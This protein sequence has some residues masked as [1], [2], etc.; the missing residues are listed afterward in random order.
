MAVED[1]VLAFVGGVD[2]LVGTGDFEERR[3]LI[4]TTDSG[5]GGGELAGPGIAVHAAHDE[6]EVG[7][8]PLLADDVDGAVIAD[9][10]SWQSGDDPGAARLKSEDDL[11]AEI[12]SAD[13]IGRG[14]KWL[15]DAH[16][17][18]DGGG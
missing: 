7:R 17:W 4:T 3:G 14:E 6:F 15:I 11:L 1:M 5:D 16:D 12:F 18:R 9:L 13:R 2:D 10:S 8:K